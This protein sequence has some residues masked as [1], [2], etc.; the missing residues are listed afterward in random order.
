M[1]YK[2]FVYL[3]TFCLE[4]VIFLQPPHRAFIRINT[5]IVVFKTI[6]AAGVSVHIRRN[7]KTIL[8]VQSF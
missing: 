8:E 5:V 2:M 3:P 4:K 6:Q 7:Y 1:T